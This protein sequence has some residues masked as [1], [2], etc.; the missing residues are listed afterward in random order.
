MKDFCV[1]TVMRF[2]GKAGFLACVAISSFGFKDGD[3]VLFL[4]D[5][6]TPPSGYPR[7]ICDYCVTR[8][9]DRS[10]DIEGVGVPGDG[11]RWCGGRID[12]E[13]ISR[14]PDVLSVMFGMNDVEHFLPS[15]K[16][17]SDAETQ[18]KQADRLVSA[19]KT[20]HAE[21]VRRVRSALPNVR[22][23]WI[24]PTPYDE[25]SEGGRYTTNNHAGVNIALSGVAEHVR[26]SAEELDYKVV[27]MNS[28]M[29]SYL[30]GKGGKYAISGADRVH[31]NDLGHLYIA[32]Q[33][34][35][36]TGASP[37]VSDMAFDCAERRV[38]RQEN[39]E[40]RDFAVSGDG[41]VSF[42]ALEK[43]LPLPID[44]AFEAFARD[45]GMIDD[46]SREIVSFTGLDGGRWILL[47]DGAPVLSASAE[48]LAAGVNLSL[49]ETPQMRQAQTVRLANKTRL[50]ELDYLLGR[51]RLARWAL[52]R[53]SKVDIDN[54]AEVKRF[55]D[56]MPREKRGG[57][58]WRAVKPYLENWERREDIRA[59]ISERNK[60]IRKMAK[61]VWHRYELVPARDFHVDAKSGN[62][63]NDGLS[64]ERA[65]RTIERASR[66]KFSAGDRLLLRAGCVWRL[67]KTF[68]IKACGS[69]ESPI[70]LTR[71]GD[72]TAPELRSSLD[73]TSLDWNL[74]TNGLWSASCGRIDIGN[75]VWDTGYGFKKPFLDEVTSNGDF[76]HDGESGKLFFKC[77][78]NPKSMCHS[79]ELARKITV[80]RIDNA[81]N[82]E[83][84]GI[85]LGYT[86]SH[87]IRGNNAQHVKIR[88]CT[89]G[90]IGGSFLV[91]PCEKKPQGVRYGN[92]IEIWTGGD[93]R[94][95]H[96]E[97]CEFHDIYDVAI[98]T[99]GPLEGTLDEVVIASNRISRCEQGYEF[100]VSNPKFKAG[101][102]EVIGNNFEDSGLGWSHAQR[103]NKIATHILSYNVKCQKGRIVLR[104]NRFGRTAQCAIWLFG[105]GAK[106]WLEV[107][108]NDVEDDLGGVFRW[109]EKGTWQNSKIT[110]QAVGRAIV[111][112]VRIAE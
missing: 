93:S 91:E 96:I 105:V 34:L 56:E 83:I 68:H 82:L 84:D 15:W 37:M 28:T 18:R 46:I 97:G 10:I 59:E 7:T 50:E 5:S 47:I 2:V 75:I 32:W 101:T 9:P 36:Q 43:A 87:G 111:R 11:V 85:S 60:V 33:F 54:L 99:Q 39:V 53:W 24:T 41:H 22:I 49:Y 92:G 110:C 94:N 48:K 3:R 64:A 40:V 102:V 4:G 76:W 35:K 63:E 45:S 23:L 88:E 108:E 69:I 78:G 29:L 51:F 38:L 72:G 112:P 71:Y 77:H 104:G 103:P 67:D 21:L 98:T 80:V 70:V 30:K 58:Q 31:P 74:E 107:G 19:F 106:E 12:E 66:Q 95:I 6:I 57:W 109:R 61:P 27:D 17:G 65:W 20:G 42:S 86:G 79:L 14:K 44:P 62:D 8:Y 16:K 1:G 25:F 81:S 90:W 52:R 100:W 26:R 13:I 89:F 55:M 73:G